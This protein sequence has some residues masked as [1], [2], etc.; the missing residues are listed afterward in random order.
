MACGLLYILACI[1][2]NRFSRVGDGPIA[3]SSAY[4]DHEVGAMVQLEMVIS[5]ALSSLV[6]LLILFR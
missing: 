3:G 4:A 2:C 5:D 1:I 6:M